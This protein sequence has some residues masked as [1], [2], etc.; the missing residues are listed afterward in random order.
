MALVSDKL[1]RI[2]PSATVAITARALE[3]KSNG[4]DVIGLGA[5]E[6]DM[7]TPRNIQD[8]AIDAMH[9]GKIRYTAVDGIPELKKAICDKFKRDN[10]L[11]YTPG[12]ISV[13]SGGKQ[14][15]FNAMLA[16]LNAGDEVIVPAPYWV[17]YPEIVS[18]CDGVP[19]IV[20]AGLQTNFKLTAGMLE[21]A[22][23]P[24]TKWLMLNSPS[25]PTGAAYSFDEMKAL[26][27]VLLKHPHVWIFADDIYEHLVFGDFE[28]CTPAQVEPKLKNRTL[29]MNGVSKSYAMTGWRIGY[30]GGPKELIDGMR[31]VM[32]QTTSCA[33]AVG[34]YAALEA[35]NGPQDFIDDNK[36]IF[37]RRRDLVVTALNA[38]EGIECPTPE[39]AF[40]VYPS[41]AKLIGTT[42]AKGTIIHDDK[43]FAE[44]LLEESGVAVV[45]GAA[46]GCSPN[47]RVSYATSD[48]QLVEACARIAKFCA[49]LKS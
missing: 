1:N 38:I 3:M 20:E 43:A 6:P 14:V 29:T 23:T 5:G 15:I 45:F 26:A 41:I 39:G 25:N 2:Q 32:M 7:E 17:S 28:F 24:K 10:D 34:Q 31:K 37:Q 8:A 22:I 48:D 46:F 30:A 35:L 18:L 16:T 42:S 47:F 49:G 19:V 13:A 44:A 21:K 40:Y 33:S 12:E 27:D 4:E 9:S 11:I 36:A